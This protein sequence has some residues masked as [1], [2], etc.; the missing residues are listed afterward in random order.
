MLSWK[1]VIGNV[2]AKGL[3]STAALLILALL[4]QIYSG[5]LSQQSA[6]PAAHSDS[7]TH[8]TAEHT[9]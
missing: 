7:G 5:E 3:C 4:T 1:R 8:E 6:C 9:P 2:R